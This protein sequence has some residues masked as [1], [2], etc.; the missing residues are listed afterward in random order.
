MRLLSALGLAGALAL[1]GC[2]ASNND[3]ALD[4]QAKA[5]SVTASVTT[6]PAQE[7]AS[8]IEEG[9]VVLIDVRT[10]NEFESE[11]L[12]GS[13]NAPVGSFDAKSIPRDAT[14]ETILYCRSSGR[15]K[16]AAEMLAAE[17]NTEVR[18]LEGGILAW[19]EAELPIATP[20]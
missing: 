1:A 7:L 9:K 3:I 11:R 14:R 2:A 16:R 13:L 17:W 15:S 4:T 10:P 12:A 5:A 18:H 19:K 20:E 8:L 6:L